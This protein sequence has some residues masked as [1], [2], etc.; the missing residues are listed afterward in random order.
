MAS[1]GSRFVNPADLVINL[2]ASGHTPAGA[3][4]SVADLPAWRDT[5]PAHIDYNARLVAATWLESLRTFHH[6]W[7]RALVSAAW[8][9]AMHRRDVR[10]GERWWAPH[11]VR[12][13]RWR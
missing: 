4:A 8:K 5:D 7:S 9:W 1:I 6:P 3:E 2:I 13:V 12:G 11:Q 10:R